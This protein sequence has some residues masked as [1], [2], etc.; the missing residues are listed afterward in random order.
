MNYSSGF[1]PRYAWGK[2]TTFQ[3]TNVG[4]Q[5]GDVAYGNVSPNWGLNVT[6]YIDD[7]ISPVPRYNRSVNFCMYNGS[8]EAVIHLMIS[9]DGLRK[10]YNVTKLEVLL[11]DHVQIGSHYV[12][13][14]HDLSNFTDIVSANL[15]FE[16]YNESVEKRAVDF[17]LQFDDDPLYYV[18]SASGLVSYSSIDDAKLYAESVVLYGS[19][20]PSIDVTTM[21]SF[22]TYIV[23]KKEYTAS[24]PL[25]SPKASFCTL[26][27]TG[28]GLTEPVLLTHFADGPFTRPKRTSAGVLSVGASP[29][30]LTTGTKLM[31]S[32]TET[33]ELFSS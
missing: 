22:Y 26:E 3:I 14:T 9:S 21:N 23:L 28:P 17:F 24:Y 18:T 7:Y 11:D 30:M 33:R 16:S 31:V 25:L 15:G 29:S 8:D 27:V 32:G 1:V 19:R 4:W 12:L 13:V 5:S 10:F 20:V 2:S 6:N